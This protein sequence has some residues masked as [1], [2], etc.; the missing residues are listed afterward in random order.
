[1]TS[2]NDLI[3]M[4]GVTESLARIDDHVDRADAHIQQYK[5]PVLDNI[6]YALRVLGNGGKHLRAHL[7]HIAAA[8]AEGPAH[9]AAIVFGA[10]VELLHSAFLVHDDII[11]GDDMRRGH[12][13]IHALSRHCFMERYSVDDE[14]TAN[15]MGEGIGIVSGDLALSWVYELIAT[16]AID[17]Q[18]K[19]DAITVVAQTS[20]VTIYGE[21]LDI[22]HAAFEHIELDRIRLSNHL[23]TSDYSFVAPLRL[24]CIAA[25]RDPEPFIEIGNELGRAFQAADDLLGTLGDSDATGKMESDLERGRTTLL[26]SRMNEAPES[27]TAADEVAAEA[28]AHLDRARKLTNAADIHERSRDGLLA[29]ADLIE[30]MVDRF[31]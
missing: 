18:V 6:H 29:V 10:A 4:P 2:S 23:K 15:R 16:A 9:E 24:G 26:T 28:R 22:E 27:M 13:T 11:D 17:P 7:V 12:G 25:G 21:M 1:M 31:A 3:S 8:G 5:S 30:K 19:A 14:T 20:A